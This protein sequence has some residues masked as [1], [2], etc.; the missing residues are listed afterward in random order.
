VTIVAVS[1]A[2]TP[3]LAAGDALA[4]DNISAEIIDL[5]SLAPI[6]WDTILGSVQK[7]GRLVAVDIAHRTCSAAS[8]I[9]AT[10]AEK[11]F[12]DLKAPIERVTTPDVHIPFSP[13]LEK[14][15]YPSKESIVAA[16]AR[17]FS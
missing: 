12:W 9:A 15:L 4:A 11:G 17:T 14:Q 10:V 5:R 7:T 8:E 16:V 2:M 3:A 6:D 1:G 13:S